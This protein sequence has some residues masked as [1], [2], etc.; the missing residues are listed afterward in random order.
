M[1]HGPEPVPT[2]AGLEPAAASAQKGPTE[3]GATEDGPT[4]DGPARDGPA[5]DGPARDGPI[6]VWPVLRDS[7]PS[8]PVALV[9]VKG[10]PP[11]GLPGTAFQVP[12]ADPVGA[13]LF[14]SGTESLAV[15]DERRPIDLAALRDDPVFGS[16][17]VTIHPAATMIRVTTPPGHEAMLTRAPSGWRVSMVPASPRPAPL[18]PVPANGALTFAAEAPGQQGARERVGGLVDIPQRQASVEVGDARRI[19]DAAHACTAAA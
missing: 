15:F 4:P 14:T 5:R 16:A 12:F 6:Q 17:V 10:K 7:I 8:G 13:A 3:K 11:G 9:A 18:T 1:E 2:K 19:R